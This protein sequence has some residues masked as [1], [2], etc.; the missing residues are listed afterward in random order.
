M[1][2]AAASKHCL[3]TDYCIIACASPPLITFSVQSRHTGTSID[4][5]QTVITFPVEVFDCIILFFVTFDVIGS[6]VCGG[7]GINPY[8]FNSQVENETQRGGEGVE[9]VRR[10]QNLYKSGLGTGWNQ[11]KFGLRPWSVCWITATDSLA[12]QRSCPCPSVWNI[13]QQ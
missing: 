9:L 4:T 2:A 5:E 11:R 8:L 1:C 12:L 7:I 13:W 6:A 10:Q 3:K